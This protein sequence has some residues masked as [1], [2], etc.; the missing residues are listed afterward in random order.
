MTTNSRVHLYEAGIDTAAI[1]QTILDAIYVT[2]GMGYQYLWVDDFCIV[3]DS[4]LNKVTELGKM[5]SI[6]PGAVCTICVI[7]AKAATEGFLRQAYPERLLRPRH[8]SQSDS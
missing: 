1:P 4:G 2:I 8:L 5:A 6:Y 3:Q 7:G